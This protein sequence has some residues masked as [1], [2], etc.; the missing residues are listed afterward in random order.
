MN[1]STCELAVRL[2][3]QVLTLD[4]KQFGGE[5]HQRDIARDTPEI[6]VSHNKSSQDLNTS[7]FDQKETIGKDVLGK[8]KSP[9]K[10]TKLHEDILGE[11]VK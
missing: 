7:S 5:T 1:L 6:S 9:I 3:S 2:S 10:T 11:D 8:R 4:L